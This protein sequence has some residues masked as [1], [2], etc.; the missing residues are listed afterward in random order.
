MNL[1]LIPVDLE[2]SL[3]STLEKETDPDLNLTESQKGTDITVETD[4]EDIMIDEHLV[5]ILI[6]DVEIQ[7][8]DIEGA[9]DQ[10]REESMKDTEEDIDL[11]RK[12]IMQASTKVIEEEAHLKR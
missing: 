6:K 10:E 1:A 5:E 3:V 7:E 4:L 12:I 2:A 8:I 9:A 11:M